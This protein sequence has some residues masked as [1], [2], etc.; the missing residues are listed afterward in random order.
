M[1][2]NLVDTLQTSDE[3]L[4]E[5]LEQFDMYAIKMEEKKGLQDRLFGGLF[6]SLDK[7]SSRLTKHLSDRIADA[8]Q[9]SRYR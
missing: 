9:S 3:F 6:A 5:A 7:T 4:I 1:E 2:L 8:Q